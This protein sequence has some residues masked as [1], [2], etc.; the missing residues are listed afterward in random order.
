M[1]H[2]MADRMHRLRRIVL[3]IAMLGLVGIAVG[4]CSTGTPS[5]DQP[6]A[7]APVPTA[8]AAG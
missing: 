4:A 2:V 7:T 3:A 8:T 5:I 1:P 6:A